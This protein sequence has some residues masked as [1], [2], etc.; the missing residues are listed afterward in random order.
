MA[1]HYKMYLGGKW[2]DRRNRITVTNPY[3]D[4]VVGTVAAA[5]KTDYTK[6][7]S[8]AEKT[9]AVTRDLP[10]YKREETCLAVAAGLEKNIDK[11][12]R[13]MSM[14]LGKAY[15]DAK[16]EITRA[17]GVFKTAAEEAKRI[18]GEIIDLD[19]NPGAEERIGLVRRF[20]KGVIAGI[21]PF[22]F[23]VNLVAHKVAPAIASGNTI[24]LKPA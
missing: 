4:S 2:V 18:A 6:A 22:N 5:S 21:S 3:D 16:G 12:A 9:F 23:P 8:I 10:S 14:E 1:K 11:M 24:V 13:T 20:P 19:W 17:I 15:K 7:I